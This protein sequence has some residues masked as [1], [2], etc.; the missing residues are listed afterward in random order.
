MNPFVAAASRLAFL[1]GVAGL[2]SVSGCHTVSRERSREASVMPTTPGAYGPP[3]AAQLAKL[4]TLERR[5]TQEADTEPA[6][7]NSFW[8]NHAV[9]LY[10]DV[11]N[12]EPLFSSQDKFESGTGWPSFT[13][14][15]EASHVL[16]TKDETHGMVRTEVRSAGGRSHLGHLFEDGPAPTGL[17]YCINSASLRFV[18]FADLEKEGYGAYRARFLSATGTPPPAATNNACAFPQP[19]EKAGCSA[20]LAVALFAGPCV[21]RSRDMVQQR[22]RHLFRDGRQRRRSSR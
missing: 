15:V 8:D 20:T 17:R 1:V 7:Q 4:S 13:R 18:P 2:A 19:G 14:P 9:G 10:V 3:T 21:A 5:V 6:F 22:E 16:S 12:G 11:V